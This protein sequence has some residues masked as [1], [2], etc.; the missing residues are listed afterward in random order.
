MKM[1]LIPSVDGPDFKVEKKCIF[2]V[3][4][5]FCSQNTHVGAQKYRLIK[6]VLYSW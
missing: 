3:F 5:L 4:A 2:D 6:A 1:V